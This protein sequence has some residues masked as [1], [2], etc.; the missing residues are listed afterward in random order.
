MEATFQM[1]E[2]NPKGSPQK[3]EQQTGV[4]KSASQSYVWR[5]LRIF[6]SKLQTGSRIA[7]QEKHALVYYAEFPF[8][9]IMGDVKYLKK[10]IYAK[11]CTLTCSVVCTRGTAE[12]Y[13]RT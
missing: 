8:K 9:N 3:T 6:S 11:N 10:V 7:D 13:L 2:K 1:L 4:Y 12:L 5:E